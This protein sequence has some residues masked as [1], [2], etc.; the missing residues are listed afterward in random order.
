M[1]NIYIYKY[2]N[3][4]HKFEFGHIDGSESRRLHPA[5][6]KKV[7][8]SLTTNDVKGAWHGTISEKFLKRQVCFIFFF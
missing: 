8:F 6:S 4:R 2:K 1:V 7:N 5:Q 3:K